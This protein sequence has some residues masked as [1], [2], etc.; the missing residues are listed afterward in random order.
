MYETLL[1]IYILF[2]IY[3]FIYIL[4]IY[5][6]GA[7]RR[8]PDSGPKNVLVGRADGHEERLTSRVT[9]T[10]ITPAHPGAGDVRTGT[11]DS[12]IPRSH[13]ETPETRVL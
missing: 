12:W 3:F 13:R 7:P 10:S 8:L 2:L 9:R 1:Y 11:I 4:D 6:C 5:G